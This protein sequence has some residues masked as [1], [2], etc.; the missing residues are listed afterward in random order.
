MLAWNTQT[1]AGFDFE[2]F[3]G[4]RRIPVTLDGCKLVS[5]LPPP[6]EK[7]S[8]AS[9]RQTTLPLDKSKG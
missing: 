3:G 7:R 9:R 5:F 8:R 2:T 4:N 6:K 1:E